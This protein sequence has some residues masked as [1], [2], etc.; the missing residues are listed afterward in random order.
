MPRSKAE[1]Q[2][3]ASASDDASQWLGHSLGI[4]Y[5]GAVQALQH[6]VPANDNG[7]GALLQ[8]RQTEQQ[9]LARIRQE[10]SGG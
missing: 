6:C 5:R 7:A 4:Q 9:H 10:G 3:G 2:E 1:S 8:F